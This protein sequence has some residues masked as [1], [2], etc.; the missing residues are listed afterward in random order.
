MYYI[1][2]LHKYTLLILLGTAAE[3]NSKWARNA[4]FLGRTR[5]ERSDKTIQ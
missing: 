1:G 5:T 3:R 4:G 2:L